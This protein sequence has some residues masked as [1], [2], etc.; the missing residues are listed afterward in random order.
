M[1]Q[2]HLGIRRGFLVH[3]VPVE[4]D[5]E[6]LAHQAGYSSVSRYGADVFCRLASLDYLKLGP[7]VELPLSAL[8]M[9]LANR[10]VSTAPRT[11]K[12]TVRIP[13]KVKAEELANQ[14]G[15]GSVSRFARDTFCSLAG[16]TD[17]M[18]GPDLS[19]E[20]GNQLPLTA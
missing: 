8:P 4:V 13:D 9:P 16:R 11:H 14:A 10:I 17:L 15:Y 3:G 5:V 7:D 6:Q 1:A 20:G 19:H 2:P 12:Y 18:L